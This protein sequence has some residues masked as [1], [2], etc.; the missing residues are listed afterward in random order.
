MVTEQHKQ[1]ADDFVFIL[2]PNHSLSWQEARCF[3]CCVLLLSICIATFFTLIGAWLVI[4]FTGFEMLLLGSSLYLTSLA[5]CRREVIN[6]HD[7]QIEITRG[8]HHPTERYE[9]QRSWVK[10]VLTHNRSDWYPSR[11]K[12]RSHGKEFEIGS[13][14]TE[15]EREFL[16]NRLQHLIH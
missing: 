8:I 4:P 7:H 11:L 2:S 12:L 6:I 1:E 14:L 9:L 5:G 13:F 16:A 3:F 10:V 15:D